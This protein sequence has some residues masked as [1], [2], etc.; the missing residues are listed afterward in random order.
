MP[1]PTI[2]QPNLFQQEGLIQKMP[3]EFLMQDQ[4]MGLMFQPIIEQHLDKQDLGY[5][6]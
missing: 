3:L 1:K 5:E 2:N 6:Q 4:V